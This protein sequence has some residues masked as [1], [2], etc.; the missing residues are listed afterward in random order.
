[1]TRQQYLEEA[2]SEIIGLTQEEAEEKG[3]ITVVE[4]PINITTRARVLVE[5]EDE[6]IKDVLEVI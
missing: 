4:R 3:Y 5:L 6:K 1:M 2:E